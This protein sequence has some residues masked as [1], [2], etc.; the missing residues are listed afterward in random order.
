MSFVTTLFSELKVN[1]KNLSVC[2]ICSYIILKNFSNSQN[3][4]KNCSL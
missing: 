2:E 1:L 4:F 3:A